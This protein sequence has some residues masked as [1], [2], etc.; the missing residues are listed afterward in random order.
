MKI[1]S[2]LLVSLLSV[3]TPLHAAGAK[4]TEI[5]NYEFPFEGPFGSFDKNQLQRGLK[6]YTQVC[7]ACHGLEYVSFRNLTDKGGPEFTEEQAREYAKNFEVF[8]ET[9]FDGEGDYR[10][11][12]L[13][14]KF[15]SSMVK[16]APDLS[17]MTKGRA[18][19]H[20]PYGLGINQ[21]LNG[22]GGPE[23]VASLLTSYTGE[24]KEQAGVVLYEN[25]A[26][27]GGWINMPPPLYGDDVV[28]D[29]GAPTDVVS[30]SKDV[31][32][33]L[34]WA[35]E[36]KLNQRKQGGFVAIVFLSILTVLL[37]LTTKKIFREK[38][39]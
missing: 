15:P 5:T 26:Y 11:A 30:Q 4:D 39:K 13:I 21:F 9:L 19:F 28:F 24:T 16:N 36:P 10:T 35:A 3:S 22:I 12:K 29:D 31:A 37:Y 25:K 8:D 18:G 34:H 14:D 1:F 23:Y 20:G 32:A 27:P 7:S 2:V 6:V 33:F 17:L 38:D